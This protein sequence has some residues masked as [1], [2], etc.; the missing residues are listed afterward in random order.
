MTVCNIPNR[1][2]YCHDNLDVLRGINSECI[3]LIYLDPPFNKNKEFT[4]PIGSSA[5]GVQFKDI[6]RNEDVKEEWLPTIRQDY[7]QLYSFLE[8]IK[9]V[10]KAYN[11]A[12]V[13]CMSIRT[14]ECHRVLKPTGSLYLHC[15]T[16]MSSHLKLVMDAIFSEENYRSQIAWRRSMSSQKG[17]QHASKR[18]GNNT[19]IILYY[20]KSKQVNLNPYR[21]PVERER[22]LRFDRVDD[23]GKRYYDD[24]AHIW[25][26]PS[27]GARPNL[28]Y[29]WRGFRNPHP[30]GWR[31]STE[32][33]EEEYKKGNFVILPNGRLQR[34]KYESDYR[35]FTF[36]NF[37]DD[38]NFVLGDE[39]VGYPTQKPIALLDRIIKA[40]SNQDDIVL[41]PFCGCATACVSAERLGRQWIGVDVSIKAYELV[42]ERLTKEAADAEDLFKYQ[43]E[44]HLHTDPPIRTD[45]GK[46]YREKKF[47]YVISHP[48]YSG[49]YKV[50]IAKDWKSR[51]NAYQTSDPDR[52][53]EVEF[54]LEMPYFRETEAYIHQKFENKHEWVQ[55]N[56]KEIIGEIKAYKPA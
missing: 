12:Y 28:C 15:D 56:L 13:A 46:D 8:G 44:I 5:E 39:A 7:P 47:V 34:R 22:I 36:G 18:W 52:K 38:I 50:G 33:L 6:F 29:E 31:L 4:A 3:D 25:R 23:N 16:T 26:N 10:G 11:F 32:R 27:M 53:Y 14:I 55:G 9:G 21:E 30:S 17:S 24:S 43:N 45:L 42:K 20:S 35:G 37:W 1:T 51:L 49:E 48:K 19:D 41:D 40:S 54:K 2:V